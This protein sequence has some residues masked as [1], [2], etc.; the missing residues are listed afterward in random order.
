MIYNPFSSIIAHPLP[1]K[2]GLSNYLYWDTSLLQ[3]KLATHP[4]GEFI[5]GN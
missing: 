4:G 1:D 2:K 5:I 3:E